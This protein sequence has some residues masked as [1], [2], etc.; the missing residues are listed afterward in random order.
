MVVVDHIPNA[1]VASR[2]F[3]EHYDGGGGSWDEVK[4]LSAVIAAGTTRPAGA[5]VTLFKALGM[6][7]SD[8]SVA[9]VV[10]ERAKAKG[11]GREIPKPARAVAR[12]KSGRKTAVV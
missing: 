11:I 9:R 8:L 7:I 5:D 6:G 2:E 12:W 4:E 3:K 10:Y 1:K